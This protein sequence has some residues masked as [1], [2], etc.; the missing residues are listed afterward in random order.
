VKLASP[1]VVGAALAVAQAGV[2][3]FAVAAHPIGRTTIIVVA[4]RFLA[5][6]AAVIAVLDEPPGRRAVAS[7]SDR[8]RAGGK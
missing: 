4:L 1:L 5:A 6:S 3:L 7:R 8:S 2:S